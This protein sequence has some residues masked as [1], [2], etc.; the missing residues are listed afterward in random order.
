MRSAGSRCPRTAAQPFPG[1]PPAQGAAR[2][3]PAPGRRA[4]ERSRPCGTRRGGRRQG[5]DACGPQGDAATLER[6][7]CPARPPLPAGHYLAPPTVLPPARP[8]PPSGGPGLPSSSAPGNGGGPAPPPR[9]ALTGC[10]AACD[11]TKPSSTQPFVS[12]PAGAPGT[13]L[14]GSGRWRGALEGTERGDKAGWRRK[15][16]EGQRLPRPPDL[17]HAAAPARPG[18]L[19]RRG[20]L[21]PSRGAAPGR[22]RPPCSRCGRMGQ[23]RPLRHPPLG[24]PARPG[25]GGLRSAPAR[26]PWPAGPCASCS[27]PSLRGRAGAAGARYEKINRNGKLTGSP[28]CASRR[29]YVLRAPS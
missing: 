28:A 1:W 2:A 7:H 15:G 29:G 11:R 17:R 9:S 5:T 3:G 22:R 4:A 24:R 26:A 18:H 6:R 14:A 21:R 25:L 16:R 27:P 20:R 12:R 23:S 10:A 13:P 19:P 8:Q